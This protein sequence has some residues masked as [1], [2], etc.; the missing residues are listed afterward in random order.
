[1]KQ[2][3]AADAAIREQLNTYVDPYLSQTLGEAKAVISVTVA[4]GTVSVELGLGFP[5]AD[6]G[7][8]L[9]AALRDHLKPLL[10]PA[11][12]ELKLRPQI[13]AH[14]VQRTLKP[15]ANIKNIV[16]V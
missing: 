10:G 5:C 14:A 13:T 9:E 8:E 4:P 1:M 11:R 3:D 12:L 15:L 16:A 7:A 2:L 6:Y